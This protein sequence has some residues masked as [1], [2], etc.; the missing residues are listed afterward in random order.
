MSSMSSWQLLLVTLKESFQ[1]KS[2]SLLAVSK[3][4][5]PERSSASTFLTDLLEVTR[6]C[7]TLKSLSRRA[8]SYELSSPILKSRSQKSD[9]RH[10]LKY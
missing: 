4:Y 9:M 2:Q 10:K 8:K 1:N 6:S 3:Q 5:H 7:S